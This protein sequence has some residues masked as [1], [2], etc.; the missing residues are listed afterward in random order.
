MRLTVHVN[1]A[2][3][4]GLRHPALLHSV[5]VSLRGPARCRSITVVLRKEA[6][7]R[8]LGDFNVQLDN[9]AIATAE[10]APCRLFPRRELAS[11][12]GHEV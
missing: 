3:V 11:L 7:H 9:R 12:R 4:P 1:P 5:S 6:P 2:K 8:E 10:R